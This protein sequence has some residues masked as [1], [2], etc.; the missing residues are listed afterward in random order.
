ML[1]PLRMWLNNSY[2]GNVN[3]KLNVNV[4]GKMTDREIQK[5]TDKMIYE[6]RKKL[7]RR[8]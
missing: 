3:V 1:L 6:I 2:G 8:I 4:N 5:T 7:G